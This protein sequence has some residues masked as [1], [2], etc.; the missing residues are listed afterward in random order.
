MIRHDLGVGR[1]NPPQSLVTSDGYR[2]LHSGCKPL[3]HR[4]SLAFP[5]LEIVALHAA[6]RWMQRTG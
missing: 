2:E 1:K 6:A 4:T 5:A 3:K